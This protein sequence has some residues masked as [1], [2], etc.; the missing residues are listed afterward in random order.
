[1]GFC[2]LC[3]STLS[4]RD[5]AGSHQQ[6][7]DCCIFLN[8]LA[9]SELS[10]PLGSIRAE[11]C[12]ASHGR[13]PFEA[14]WERLQLKLEHS[15]GYLHSKH[16][17]NLLHSHQALRAIRGLDFMEVSS[18]FV[19]SASCRNQGGRQD[20]SDSCSS[21]AS[22]AGNACV[23]VKEELAFPSGIWHSDGLLVSYRVGEPSHHCWLFRV[24]AV[25]KG[26]N[27]PC[28]TRNS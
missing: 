6:A 16:L 26:N 11:C 13:A 15:V 23:M 10:G 19:G 18:C 20:C 25:A 4:P 7:R 9:L 24:W 17:Q 1:M 12:R 8:A 3:V 27:P 28:Q 5:P 2:L 22:P 14:T 21:R